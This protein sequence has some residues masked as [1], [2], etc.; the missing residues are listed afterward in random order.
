MTALVRA[1]EMGGLRTGQWLMLA[2]LMEA[3]AAL[4]YFNYWA[5]GRKSI[6]YGAG[7]IYLAAIGMAVGGVIFFVVGVVSWLR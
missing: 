1:A 2:L 5:L 4:T 3:L 7:S 6:G